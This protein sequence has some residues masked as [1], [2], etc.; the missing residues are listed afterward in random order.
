MLMRAYVRERLGSVAVP[1]IAE[2]A[3][4]FKML[5]DPTRLRIL[6]TLVSGGELCVHE[7][8]ARVKARQ[9]AVSHQ[10]RT[11]RGA[12]LVRSRRDGRE[13]YYA[14]DDEHVLRLLSEGLN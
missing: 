9:P 8:C 3:G 6:M 7:I 4:I 12:R 1:Q 2:L 14:L 5:A 13:I 10:L 11:L